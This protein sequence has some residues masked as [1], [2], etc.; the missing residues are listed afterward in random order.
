MNVLWIR[1]WCYHIV[2]SFNIEKK[3]GYLPNLLTYD[4]LTRF[5]RVVFFVQSLYF[6]FC[7][8]RR[9]VMTF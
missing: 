7:F 1:V 4:I 5:F 9:Q 8:N 6:F 2:P 3:S